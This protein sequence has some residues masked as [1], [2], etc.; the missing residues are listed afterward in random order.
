MHHVT[1]CKLFA[2]LR[3]ANIVFKTNNEI[4]V[5]DMQKLREL[6]EGKYESKII[7]EKP[8]K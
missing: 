2:W 3:Q 7:F 6:I 8:N 4:I 5:N 1:V